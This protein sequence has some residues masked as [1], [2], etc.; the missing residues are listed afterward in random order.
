[1]YIIDGHNLIPNVP[2]LSLEAVDDEEKLLAMLQVYAR[3]RR[4]SQIEVYFDGAPPG[5]AGVRSYGGIRAHFVS[6][7]LTADSAIQRRLSELGRRARN[8]S[9][10]SSDRQV[11]ASARSAQAR[12]I[13]CDEFARE[14]LSAQEEHQL[15][16]E[17]AKA[18]KA[19]GVSTAPAGMSPKELESWLDLFG[20]DPARADAPIEPPRPPPK[21]PRKKKKK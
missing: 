5:Q 7:G 13:S 6:A 10:V 1:M 12:V 3:V 18:Q 19:R 14:L 21:P 4:R 20:I 16:A 17:K 15:R 9:V 11:Q 8:A 2:G